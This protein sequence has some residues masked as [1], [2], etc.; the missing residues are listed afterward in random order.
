[1]AVFAH[2]FS[3][4]CPDL[5]CIGLWG[6]EQAVQQ[7]NHLSCHAVCNVPADERPHRIRPATTQ[8]QWHH[9]L[10]NHT[11]KRNIR[12]QQDRH[13][14]K[15]KGSVSSFFR[16]ARLSLAA[17]QI[18]VERKAECRLRD[19]PGELWIPLPANGSL[20]SLLFVP[21][22]QTTG[23]LWIDSL[24]GWPHTHYQPRLCPLG[25]LSKS[26][27]SFFCNDFTAATLQRKLPWKANVRSVWS[28][29]SCTSAGNTAKPPPGCVL[30]IDKLYL[31]LFIIYRE[32]R[33]K[34]TAFNI[35]F[36]N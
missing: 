29:C 3:S 5:G 12:C 33:G 21:S 28:L 31:L 19:L 36:L 18:L 7:G 26:S 11:M 10:Q 20:C 34:F 15:E 1:M 23:A 35:P 32:T 8:R 24:Y 4:C 13:K 27:S 30:V 22:G 2:F 17:L 14:N 16:T 6:H 25:C 9:S